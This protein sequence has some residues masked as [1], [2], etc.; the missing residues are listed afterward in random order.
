MLEGILARV[1][2]ALDLEFVPA[3]AGNLLAMDFCSSDFTSW[4]FQVRDALA[5]SKRLDIGDL[6]ADHE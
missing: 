5:D 3:G 1:D 6:I 4:Q 2:E